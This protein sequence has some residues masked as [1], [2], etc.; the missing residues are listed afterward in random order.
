VP[1]YFK[2]YCR[3]AI[4]ARVL[5]GATRDDIAAA[6]NAAVARHREEEARE[7]ALAGTCS[8]DGA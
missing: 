4:K 7:A 5:R 3:A 2:V 8:P 6:A 1:E